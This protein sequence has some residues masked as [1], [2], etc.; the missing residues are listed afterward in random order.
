[1]GD[2]SGARLSCAGAGWTRRSFQSAALRNPS[3]NHRIPRKTAAKL[4]QN[5]KLN[6]SQYSSSV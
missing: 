3:A 5:A 4:N 2:A 1:M 6:I